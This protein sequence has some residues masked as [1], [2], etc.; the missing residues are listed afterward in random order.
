M[1]N[2]FVYVADYAV[3]V[4]LVFAAIW[5]RDVERYRSGA[6]RPVVMVPGVYE[7]WHFMRPLADALHAAGHPVH[8]LPGLKRNAR[9]IVETARVTQDYLDA[10]DLRNVVVV[11]HSKGGLIAK[12]M[13]L[14]DDVESRID[15]LVALATPFGGSSMARFMPAASIREFMPTQQTLVA[16][17]A[18]AI[19]NGRVTSIFGRWDSHIP[20]GS[21]L[22]GAKN[23]EVPVPGHFRLLVHTDVIDLVVSEVHS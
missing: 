19:A 16:L 1:K 15:C 18:N 4:R 22:D 3:A 6:G 13:M 20:E 8:L 7:S 5:Q 10:N 17:A 2:P 21:T 11:A 9:P 12:H 23:I 14:V